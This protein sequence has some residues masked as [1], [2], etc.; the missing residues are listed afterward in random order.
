MIARRAVLLRL[1]LPCAFTSLTSQLGSPREVGVSA[2]LRAL[3][4]GPRVD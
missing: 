4:I 1:C 2:F 3:E